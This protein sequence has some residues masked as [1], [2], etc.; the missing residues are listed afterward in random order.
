MCRLP[1]G[2]A[3]CKRVY[4]EYHTVSSLFLRYGPSL[5]YSVGKA[6]NIGYR[7]ANWQRRFYDST[8]VTQ[9]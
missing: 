5:Y 9:L 7:T 3:Q 8:T 6:N 2:P 4:V 1:H